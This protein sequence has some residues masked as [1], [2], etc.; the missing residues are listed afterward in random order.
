MISN[1]IIYLIAI[2]VLFYVVIGLLVCDLINY[3]YRWKKNVKFTFK[4]KILAFIISPLLVL[5]WFIGLL[6]YLFL[7]TGIPDILRKAINYVGFRVNRRS[8][9]KNSFTKSAL[10]INKSS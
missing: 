8:I 9:G 1:D 6:W 7:D 5:A 10:D 4:K 3:T 2:M